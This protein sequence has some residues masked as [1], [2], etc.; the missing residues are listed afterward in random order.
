MRQ[1]SANGLRNAVRWLMVPGGVLGLAALPLLVGKQDG[2]PHLT[3][4]PALDAIARWLAGLADGSSFEYRMGGTTWNFLQT[5]PSYFME[6]FSYAVLA[7]SI[8]IAGGMVLGLRAR[9]A[10]GRWLNRILDTLFAVPDFIMAIILQLAVIVTLDMAGIKLARISHDATTG[11]VLALPLLLLSLYP[12]A[13][14][15]RVSRRA[16]SDAMREPFVMFAL[17]KGLG[18]GVVRRRHV[19]A[20]IFPVIETELPTLVGIL[21]ANL[22]MA[23]YLFSVPGITRFLFLVAFSGRRPGW[24]EWYQYQLAVDVLLG[25]VAL[26]VVEWLFFKATLRIARRAVTGEP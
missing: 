16:A 18:S 23:E 14:S 4:G 25:V 5:A 9:G 11:P 3:P 24:M 26:Y 20:A 8:G 19:G 2:I 13:W 12:L 6:S 21:H 17:S 22:F 7:G 10:A 1:L 15:F